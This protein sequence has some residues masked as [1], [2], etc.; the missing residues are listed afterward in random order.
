MALMGRNPASAP[1][2]VPLGHAKR[3]APARTARAA[4]FGDPGRGAQRPPGPWHPMLAKP[5]AFI[6][7]TSA[8]AWMGHNPRG[9]PPPADA[10][11]VASS[12]A[13]RNRRLA[14]FV[15]GGGLDFVEPAA[16]NER[17][18]AAERASSGAH[19]RRSVRGE[20][21]RK[22]CRKALFSGSSIT[23]FLYR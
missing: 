21:A 10:P 4:G 16:R 7:A 2:G 3:E 8:R 18:R 19:G 12:M 20:P 22:E 1:S 15:E 14:S 17:S 13:E 23:I 9:R 11:S 5:L 6:P